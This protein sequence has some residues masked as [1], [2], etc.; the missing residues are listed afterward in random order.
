MLLD[1]LT[2][3]PTEPLSI[4][5]QARAWVERT[6]DAMSI[7]EMIGQLFIFSTSQDSAEELGPLLALKPGGI[8][9]FPRN[10]LSAFRAASV[11]PSTAMPMC[12]WAEAKGSTWRP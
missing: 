12:A 3:P 10:D 6:R 2:P 9:R 7:E 11:E 8:N 4:D 1:S 5:E